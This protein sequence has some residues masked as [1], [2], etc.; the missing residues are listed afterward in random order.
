ML[1]RGSGRRR[2]S[3]SLDKGERDEKERWG[4]GRRGGAQAKAKEGE[5]RGEKLERKCCCGTAKGRAGRKPRQG[6][7]SKGKERKSKSAAVSQR[8]EGRGAWH[9]NGRTGKGRRGQGRRRRAKMLLWGRREEGQGARRSEGAQ[10]KAWKEREGKKRTGKERK[11][12][13]KV[14]L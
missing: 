12:R 9:R 3:A 6:K 1:L 14:L 5:G 13:E 11:A 10:A 7:V 4:C 2:S 8:E